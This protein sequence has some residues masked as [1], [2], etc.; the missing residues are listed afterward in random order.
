M[1]TKKINKFH[2]SKPAE[3]EP[4]MWINDRIEFERHEPKLSGTNADCRLGGI[5][6]CRLG[7]TREIVRRLRCFVHVG[8][9]V[10]T[11][12]VDFYEQF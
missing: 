6:L 1:N 11:T 8:R 5:I 7:I 2:P 4:K 12:T 10:M 3:D 9:G